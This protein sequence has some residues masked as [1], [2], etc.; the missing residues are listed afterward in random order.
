MYDQLSYAKISCYSIHTY[1]H[2][3]VFNSGYVENSGNL[4]EWNVLDVRLIEHESIM[5]FHSKSRL[6]LGDFNEVFTPC[7]ARC[8]KTTISDLGHHVCKPVIA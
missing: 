4:V 5:Q 1:K 2:E 7:Y 6:E 8:D 3:F